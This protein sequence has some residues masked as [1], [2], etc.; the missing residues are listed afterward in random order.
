MTLI[1][2]LLFDMTDAEKTYHIQRRL[3]LERAAHTL[4]GILRVPAKN[5]DECLAAI[6]S[7]SGEDLADML[8]D[9]YNLSTRKLGG[10]MDARSA[11]IR[12]LKRRVA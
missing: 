7:V 12:E 11:V 2:G 10:D 9:E 4:A 5:M 1:L 6:R 3:D 8:A